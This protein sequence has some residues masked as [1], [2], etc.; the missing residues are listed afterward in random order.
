MNIDNLTPDH[1]RVLRSMWTGLNFILT[2]RDRKEIDTDLFRQLNI[3]MPWKD[4]YEID[5]PYWKWIVELAENASAPDALNR[6]EFWNKAEHFSQEV[7]SKPIPL[8]PRDFPRDLI[9]AIAFEFRTALAEHFS[10]SITVPRFMH[11]IAGL[12]NGKAVEMGAGSGYWAYILSQFGVDIIA[13]DREFIRGRK[14]W[15]NVEPGKPHYLD[16]H[17]DRTLL[18]VWPH[19]AHGMDIECLQHYK[20]DRIIYVGEKGGLCGSREFEDA[21]FSGTEWIHKNT[22]V[23]A[24]FPQIKDRIFVFDRAN[25]LII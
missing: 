22:I 6:T 16:N 8:I 3:Q 20:G 23:N 7:T 9:W 24:N 5:N 11:V 4:P 17:S 13:Y 18:I 19:Y 2:E 21:L 25:K 1:Q 10:Y 14:M 15:F 12:C